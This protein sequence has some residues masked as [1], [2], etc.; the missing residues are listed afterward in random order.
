MQ[1]KEDKEKEAEEKEKAR[2]KAVADGALEL[3]DSVLG[4]IAAN[5]EQGS[6]AAKAV[7]VA[8]ATMDTYRAA[9]AAF[10]STAFL[11]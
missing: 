2:K 6:N 3:A 4:G 8:Q 5:L 11:L 7:A 9:T 10:A 1:L